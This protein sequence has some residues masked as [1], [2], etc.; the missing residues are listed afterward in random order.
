MDGYVKLMDENIHG[1]E[2]LILHLMKIFI[3]GEKYEKVHG[4]DGL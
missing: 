4:L 3:F 1:M 2:F